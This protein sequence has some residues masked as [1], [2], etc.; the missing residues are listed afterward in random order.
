MYLKHLLIAMILVLLSALPSFG[1]FTGGY[2]P[3][4]PPSTKVERAELGPGASSEQVDLFTGTLSLNY[5]FGEVATLSGLAF[6]IRLHYGSTSLLAFETEQNSGIPY[7][8]GWNL[9]NA[10][11][12]VENF[13]F[14]FT[15]SD[16]LPTDGQNRREYTSAQAKRRGE[17]Y[18]ANPTLSLPNGISGRLVYKY[19]LKDDTTKAVFMLHSFDSYAEA[20]FDGYTWE[21]ITEDGTRWLFGNVQRSYRNAGT[22]TARM[23]SMFGEQTIPRA[24]IDRWHLV[25]IS[26]PNH[27]NLQNIILEYEKHGKF[28]IYPELRQQLPQTWLK[29]YNGTQ[30]IFIADSNF[31]QANPQFDVGDSVYV[32]ASKYTAEQVH[33]DVL[34]KSVTAQDGQGSVISK[35]E[36]KYRSYRPENHYAANSIKM[37]RGKLLLLSDP[38]V[39]RNDSMYSRKTVWFRGRDLGV[40]QAH[41]PAGQRP[42]IPDTLFSAGWWRYQHPAAY[43]N[44]V[45]QFGTNMDIHPQNPYLVKFTGANINGLSPTNGIWYWQKKRATNAPIGGIK[46][47]HSVLESPRLRGS[48]LER[49]PAGDMYEIRSA[50]KTPMYV[51]M[52]FDVNLVTG[53]TPANTP[54]NFN[55]RQ[56]VQLPGGD[57]AYFQVYRDP[58]FFPNNGYDDKSYS[59][60]STFRRPAKWNP[61][62]QNPNGVVYAYTRNLFR[63]PNLPNEF[64]GFNVQIG[65]AADNLDYNSTNLSN[66]GYPYYY[67]NRINGGNRSG[68]RDLA[69]SSWFGTGAPW[70]PLY[71]QD[72]FLLF[73]GAGNS[74]KGAAQQRFK[75]WYL[76]LTANYSGSTIN[77]YGASQPTAVT[78]ESLNGASGSFSFATRS[79]HHT[80]STPQDA[81]LWNMEIVRIARNPYMLDSVIF[82]VQNGRYGVDMYATKAYKLHY[83]FE[84]VKVLNNVDH[85][86]PLQDPVAA[87][88]GTYR[89]IDGRAQYRNI[90][91]LRQIEALDVSGNGT[92]SAS[93]AQPSTQFAYYADDNGTPFIQEATLLRN[94]WNELGGKTTY[95]YDLSVVDTVNVNSARRSS[96]PD[97]THLVIGRGNVYDQHIPLSRRITE[98][99]ATTQE[100]DYEFSGRASVYRGYQLDEHFDNDYNARSKALQRR[101]YQTATVKRPSVS[102][103]GRS[104]AIYTHRIGL[105]SAEDSLL[106][107]RLVKVEE[108]NEQ[109]D[110]IGSTETDHA[111]SRVYRHGLSYENDLQDYNDRI[112]ARGVLS[113]VMDY[114]ANFVVGS[115]D[116]WLSDAWFIKPT[117]RVTTERD[118]NNGNT[119]QRT[120]HFAYYEWDIDRDYTNDVYLRMY[121]PLLPNSHF[122]TYPWYSTQYGGFTYEEEPSW[123]L[124]RTKTTHRDRPG[125]YEQQENFYLWDIG[126]FVGTY[127]SALLIHRYYDSYRPYYLSKKYGIRNVPYEQRRT[128]Y[129]G[130]P[131]AQAFGKSIYYWHDIFVDVGDDFVEV[132]DSTN[133]DRRCD[134]DNGGIYNGQRQMMTYCT[135]EGRPVKKEEMTRET[136]DDP[137]YVKHQN[138]QWYFFPVKRVKVITFDDFGYMAERDPAPVAPDC[139]AGFATGLDG[140]VKYFG[141]FDVGG[142][143][144]FPATAIDSADRNYG[145]QCH[146]GSAGI[147]EE[148]KKKTAIVVS[149]PHYHPGDTTICSRDHE[150]ANDSTLNASITDGPQPSSG[151]GG[152]AARQKFIDVLANHFFLR[153]IYEQADS[154]PNAWAHPDSSHN[155]A[156]QS[157][158]NVFDTVNTGNNLLLTPYK[159]VFR[160]LYP[161][162]RT[163]YVHERNMHGK[164]IDESNVRGAHRVYEYQPAI[165]GI[166]FDACGHRH[167]GFRRFWHGLP[168]SVTQTDFG[169]LEAVSVLRYTLTNALRETI[170]PNG[171]NEEF[172]YDGQGRLASHKMN[173]VLREEYKY[174]KWLGNTTDSWQARTEQNYVETTTWDSQT[175]SLTSTGYLD[176]LGREAQIILAAQIGPTWTKQFGGRKV[177]DKWNRIKRSYRP[178]AKTGQAN[179]SYDPVVPGSPFAESRNENDARG[180]GL[181]LSKPGN[182]IGSAR[183]VKT[184]HSI[185]TLREFKQETGATNSEIE[186]LFPMLTSVGIGNNGGG[187][188]QGNRMAAGR[189]RVVRQVGYKNIRLYRT[190]REDEDGKRSISYMDAQRV[191]IAT[192]SYTDAAYNDKV[193]TIYVT[194]VRGEQ[195]CVIHPNKLRTLSKRNYQGWPYLMR[196]P[197]A[198]ETRIMYNQAGDQVYVQDANLKASGR[199]LASDYDRLGRMYRKATVKLT[200]HTILGNSYYPLI[201]K[202]T[203]GTEFR[204]VHTIRDDMPVTDR[205]S[206]NLIYDRSFTQASFPTLTYNP[207]QRQ[208]EREIRYDY[209]VDSIVNASYI[210]P[211]ANNLLAP[212]TQARIFA[213][214]EFLKGRV[215][216]ELVYNGQGQLHEISAW[217]YSLDGEPVWT[218]RQFSA[219][220]I[221]PTMRG[222]AHAIDF[223]EYDRQHKPR[224]VNIDLNADGI[225]DVQHYYTYDHFGRLENIYLNRSDVRAAGY[226]VASY[227]YYDATHKPKFVRYYTRGKY[228]P[229]P[230]VA[231]SIQYIYDGQDRLWAM[232]SRFYQMR[233]FYDQWSVNQNF[234]QSNPTGSE[235]VQESQNYNG[236]LNGWRAQY[237]VASEGVTGFDGE[238]VYGFRYD[239]ANRLTHADASVLEQS[240][241]TSTTGYLNGGNFGT[242]INTA[243]PALY[244]DTKYQYDKAGNLTGLRRH[245]YYA[246]GPIPTGSKGDNWKYEYEAYTNHLE[247][248]RTA[249]QPNVNLTYDANGNLTSDS[250]RGIT[251]ADYTTANRMRSFQNGSSHQVSY[252]YGSAD[253][254]IYKQVNGGGQPAQG[255][256]YLRGGHGKTLARWSDAD[257]AWTMPIYGVDLIGE[258]PMTEDDADSTSHIAPSAHDQQRLGKA[259]RLLR[260]GRNMAL[261]VLVGLSTELA[262]KSET[263]QQG[264]QVTPAMFAPILGEIVD[265]IEQRLR[266]PVGGGDEEPES[267]NDPFPTKIKFYVKDHLGNVRIA[268]RP[269]MEYDTI[270]RVCSLRQDIVSVLDYYPYGK[271]LRAYYAEGQERIQTT[272]H[273]R[274]AES[275]LDYR[276]AR[277]YDADYGRFLGIDPLANKFSD[278]SPYVYVTCN[279]VIWID[280]DGR[281]PTDP[282]GLTTARLRNLANSLG[283]RGNN[284]IG[285]WFE[286]IAIQ[287]VQSH[288]PLAL[289]NREPFPSRDRGDLTNGKHNFV[290]PD[291]V[292]PRIGINTVNGVEMSLK[293]YEVKATKSRLTP[294]YRN[295]Q[296]VGMIEAVANA[297]IEA[298]N[299]NQND[300][301]SVLTLVTTS[302]TVVSQKLLDFASRNGVFIYQMKAQV[303]EDG[304]ITFTQPER[305]NLVPGTAALIGDLIDAMIGSGAREVV[306]VN[307][308]EIDR[309]DLSP[310]PGDPDPTILDD[311]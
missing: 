203:L 238:T 109:G 38:K 49:M 172:A 189:G 160:P 171:E 299:N 153:A 278:W 274:D 91:H 86:A 102:G 179:S 1:Q 309:T 270:A 222:T 231:D 8:E 120:E 104:K 71:E 30:A 269:W 188:A 50:I 107:G 219:T 3:G 152:V 158:H 41:S 281:M 297:R 35:V 204:S 63:M 79:M 268:H 255:T 18:F 4:Q 27:A 29:T 147:T 51:D 211:V 132:I 56:G 302:N 192:L 307:P 280:P 126:Q 181:R 53:V 202:D 136:M 34:L 10:A 178:Y 40:S 90:F 221:T 164:V 43:Q 184:T 108:Y 234:G 72:R 15:S 261:A 131:D 46:F 174:G 92:I 44:A 113:P 84:Q 148:S 5:D 265:Q 296:L 142:G 21:V 55:P 295:Y 155:Q 195:V 62:H 9:A 69:L 74:D 87:S 6:P 68:D 228:C 144:L 267:V 273:E 282:G 12:T 89:E 130:D 119:I 22:T 139:G 106:F 199:Y 14:D 191:E 279:P 308:L 227:E 99:G 39:L 177:Y 54:N 124:A 103:N 241:A 36:L 16:G 31:V 254:R 260:K 263:R 229:D 101:G 127:P 88:A 11:I 118:E 206:S 275:G 305:L 264:P 197:D 105:G 230:V 210:V 165:Y 176:P 173:G 150:P 244:G 226:K 45:S 232:D 183:T 271:T 143:G 187:G 291:M 194:D 140:K 23:A 298:R 289:P 94:V 81:E 78:K 7:G 57:S 97:R 82:Y 290:V 24:Q 240:F 115:S 272:Q 218:V 161:T 137:R 284:A 239:G 59:I 248:L 73:N 114:E 2:E 251:N 47:T 285:E 208:T 60:F 223:P 98:D 277:M 48:I 175:Q 61:M 201:Y 135:G 220:G 216:A 116:S 247:R 67:E 125:A 250:R 258:Y 123:Q 93:G 237:K 301:H 193:L 306:P 134:D 13:A 146:Q 25:K 200:A 243:M 112:Q 159:F 257:S 65:P 246:P 162:I 245:N 58:A 156:A 20:I 141:T 292:G 266:P 262:T 287:A 66:D 76:P 26:N 83:D 166:W 110:L 170:L 70:E 288:Y 214:Q 235:I 233:L 294:S 19:P 129:N 198:G 212:G 17:L 213:G 186:K 249:S 300:G 151:S 52:N 224:A 256:Y 122:Q 33:R 77:T 117:K 304:L 154:V 121:N 182:A 303:T 190:I 283:I 215:S 196:T 293:F 205:N 207:G 209:A 64:D 149:I 37:Q 180:R 128:T 96:W 168:R 252:I 75:Y 217:S 242:P 310:D 225:L 167:T 111:A 157:F 236:N 145:T 138:G 133:W 259:K 80:H 311:Y 28:D 276:G 32:L 253:A 286:R 42:P 185:I 163:Y 169:A 85:T 100:T 95:Q